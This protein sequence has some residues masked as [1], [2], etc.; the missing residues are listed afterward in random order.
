MIS[1]KFMV[2][3]LKASCTLDKHYLRKKGEGWKEEREKP[4]SLYVT[5]HWLYSTNAFRGLST[6][7]AFQMG[8]VHTQKLFQNQHGL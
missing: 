5:Q 3:H 2:T 8:T 7:L 6:G 1:E 4:G